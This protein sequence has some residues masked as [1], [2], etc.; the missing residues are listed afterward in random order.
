MKR[1]NTAIVLVAVINIV[2]TVVL[3]NK[4][5]ITKR[6]VTGFRES[7]DLTK[8]NVSKKKNNQD[9]EVL[10]SYGCNVKKKGEELVVKGIHVKV[11]DA[12]FTKNTDGL[13]ILIDYL[14][15][16][17]GIITDDCY[18][19]VVDAEIWC[20]RPDEGLDWF[21]VAFK[22]GEAGH[23]QTV[24]EI[25]GSSWLEPLTSKQ[26]DNGHVFING[27]YL[28]QKPEK[29]NMVFVLDECS[30]KEPEKAEMYFE[31]N[32]TGMVISGIKDAEKYAGFEEI[33]KIKFK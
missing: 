23:I 22:D 31:I 17:K 27:R 16:D 26:R 7:K 25:A 10:F 5:G 20:E 24:G 9:D 4:M 1:L 29:M 18:L 11:N 21:R 32:T 2:L 33:G 13:T 19:C 3:L 28:P 30:L 6:F 15:L 8:S 12:Y 14:K